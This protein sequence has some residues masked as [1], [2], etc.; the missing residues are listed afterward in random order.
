VLPGDGPQAPIP[1]PALKAFSSPTGM[2][3]SGSNRSPNRSPS[4]EQTPPRPQTT[5]PGSR[6]STPKKA[7]IIQP[8]NKFR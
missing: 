5:K 8:Y 4:P 6:S 2:D 1:R 3:S 7:S